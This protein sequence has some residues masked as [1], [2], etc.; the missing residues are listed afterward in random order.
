MQ[1]L[2]NYLKTPIIIKA[3]SK[4]KRKDFIPQGFKHLAEFDE[5]I[6]IGYGQT[7]SQPQV[8]A[9]MLEQLQPKP[10]NKIL[11]IGAGSGWTTALLA[12]I[13][14]QKKGGKVIAME[15]ISELAEFGRNNDKKYNCIKK[16]VVE[17]LCQNAFLGYKEQAPYDRILVSAC[18]QK[19]PQE[20]KDQLKIG[21][22]IVTSFK[23][24]IIVLEKKKQGFEQKEYSGFS[25]V[26]LIQE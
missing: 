5:P 1:F 25:F 21:G 16:G 3:F 23:S 10:G 26:P 2:K 9:F 13:V 20:W 24:S 19:I 17:F 18:A 6:P 7:I 22:K 12:Q 14:S 8:V 11:D 15:L 4:I